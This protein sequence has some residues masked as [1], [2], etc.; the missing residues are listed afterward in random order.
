MGTLAINANK[1]YKKYRSLGGQKGFTQFLDQWKQTRFSANGETN[2]VFLENRPVN[3]TVQTAIK[4]MLK[5]GGLKE[6]ESGKT[7]F[8]I[9]KAIVIGGAVL[10]AGAIIFIIVKKV[11]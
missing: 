5:E 7:V 1:A 3:D 4:N 10:L 11:K 9:P 8:G 6:E 2:G